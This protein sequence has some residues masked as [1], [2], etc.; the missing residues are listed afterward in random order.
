M[1]RGRPQMA[2]QQNSDAAI[3]C[4]VYFK[5]NRIAAVIV[6]YSGKS[7]G[8][9]AIELST[10]TLSG[11]EVRKFTV[12]CIEGAVQN[13][14]HKVSALC[15]IVVGFQGVI[16]VEGDTVLWSPI[17]QQTNIPIRRWLQEHFDAPTRIFND[18][19]LIA[20]ALHWREPEKYGN[21]FGTVLLDHG[22]GM[23]LYLRDNII[24]GTHSS[25]IEFGHMIYMPAGALC[26]CGNAGCIEAYA[27][28]YAI[29]RRARGESGQT[30]PSNVPDPP[31]L[32]AVLLA[33]SQGDANAIAAIEEAG[34]AIGTGLASL[35]ALVDRFPIVIVGRGAVLF[36]YM[37]TALRAALASAPRHSEHPPI[38]IDCFIEVGSL[39]QEGGAILALQAQDEAF[40]NRRSP[41]A[42]SP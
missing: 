39:V 2:L 4:A 18:C 23:G 24:N 28:D 33:A 27:G 38:A 36:D 6:D 8:E 35:Y 37:E 14:V 29:S 20:Q 7:V 25:G 31:D 42:V 16:D 26:R 1:G 32:D 13:T 9:Y 30:P 10:R 34:T 40:S 5:L 22:V 3:A 12:S 21:H 11:E 19:D 17:C 15:R 41:T